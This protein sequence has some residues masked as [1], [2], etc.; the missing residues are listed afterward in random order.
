M[1][2]SNSTPKIVVGI[3]LA[4]VFGV[5]VSVFAVRAKHD[6]EL[7][8]NAPPPALSA[9][10]E[11][12]ATDATGSA[13]NA[14]AQAPTDQTA[15]TTFSRVA[16]VNRGEAAMRFRRRAISPARARPLPSIWRSFAAWPRP[17]QRTPSSSET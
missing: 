13:P 2:N 16:I 8:R 5:G 10:T 3:G 6:S 7:A 17:I 11:Q 1:M 9:P 14:A 12:N 15:A 4:V